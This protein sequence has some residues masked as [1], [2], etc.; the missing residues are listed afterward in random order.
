[1]EDDWIGYQAS[2][3]KSGNSLQLHIPLSVMR[4][5]KLE[6]KDVLLVKIQ[7]AGYK[8]DATRID[9]KTRMAEFVKKKQEMRVERKSDPFIKEEEHEQNIKPVDDSGNDEEVPRDSVSNRED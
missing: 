3:Y 8:R 2:C 4:E 9:S 6:P 5:L 1:M 7:K